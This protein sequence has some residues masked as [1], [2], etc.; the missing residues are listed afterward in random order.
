[1]VEREN[2]H[3]SKPLPSFSPL[4]RR[5]C[6]CG[7]LV[8]LPHCSIWKTTAQSQCH[9]YDKNP[10]RTSEE[11][12]K[13]EKKKERGAKKLEKTSRNMSKTQ[14]RKTRK[15]SRNMSNPNRNQQIENNQQKPSSKRRERSKLTPETLTRNA[16]KA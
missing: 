1:M 7:T 6:L 11:E 13:K 3:R 9:H 5:P 8:V 10:S 16:N 4:S 15:K 12:Q 14:I 2:P